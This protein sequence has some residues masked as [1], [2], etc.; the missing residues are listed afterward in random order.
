MKKTDVINIYYIK[1]NLFLFLF[2]APGF[3]A[4]GEMVCF[5]LAYLLGFYEKNKYFLTGQMK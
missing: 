5:K 3:L 1:S 4:S 2:S